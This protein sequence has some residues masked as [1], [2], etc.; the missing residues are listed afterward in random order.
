MELIRRWRSSCKRFSLR[1]YDEYKT[2][3][4]R[5]QLTF[6]FYAAMEETN[7]P[8]NPGNRRLIFHCDEFGPCPFHAD[9]SRETIAS[10]QVEF[11]DHI[12]NVIDRW[13]KNGRKD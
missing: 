9:D 8:N 3:H 12:Q 1:L 6:K 7:D 5:R 10:I 4:G 13:L 11:W 2:R